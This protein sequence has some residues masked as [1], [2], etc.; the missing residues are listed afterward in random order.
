MKHAFIPLIFLADY[1]EQNFSGNRNGYKIGS[2]N[3]FVMMIMIL[4]LKKVRLHFLGDM[5]E[6]LCV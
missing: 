2:K 1:L 6:A 5:F 4:L 3:G